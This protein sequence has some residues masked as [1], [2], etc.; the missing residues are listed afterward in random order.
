[1]TIRRKVIMLWDQGQSSCVRDA[2]KRPLPLRSAWENGAGQ[3]VARQI[4]DGPYSKI[5]KRE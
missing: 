3:K 4:S 2:V 5:H 1:M